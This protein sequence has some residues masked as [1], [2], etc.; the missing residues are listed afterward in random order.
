VKKMLPK[1]LVGAFENISRVESKNF[2]AAWYLV[3]FGALFIATRITRIMII[4][5]AI[6]RQ[7]D[8]GTLV[9]LVLAADT[10]LVVPV[11]PGGIGIRELIIGAGG[12]AFGR[13]DVFLTAALIDRGFSIAFNMLHGIAVILSYQ[14]SKRDIGGARSD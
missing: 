14:F 3:I 5:A 8:L 9:L 4:A 10:S 11:T 13:F 1:K 7:T 6:D 12:S 2:S